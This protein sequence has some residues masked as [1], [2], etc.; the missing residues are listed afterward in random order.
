MEGRARQGKVRQCWG[1][2]AARLEDPGLGGA[3]FI[4]GKGV[5]SPGGFP[6]R[7][8][9]EGRLPVA[10]GALRGSVKAGGIS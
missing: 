3:G 4:E 9:G 5:H 6:V 8:V 10:V 2:G 1:G 7:A